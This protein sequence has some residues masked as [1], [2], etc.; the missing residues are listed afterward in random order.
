ML[1]KELPEYADMR[2]FGCLA[3]AANSKLTHDKFAHRAK[4]CVFIGYPPTTKG[5]RLLDITT[6]EAFISRDVCFEEFIFPF[7]SNSKDTYLQPLPCN[8]IC[9]PD[10]IC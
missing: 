8:A 4:P 7:N 1:F 6:K 9:R 10:S 5:Y 2:A 3:F